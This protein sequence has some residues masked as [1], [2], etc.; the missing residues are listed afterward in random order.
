MLS[1]PSQESSDT[2]TEAQTSV[3]FVLCVR[4][5]RLVRFVLFCGCVFVCVPVC[6]FVRFSA[7]C[8]F[9]PAFRC[10]CVFTFAFSLSA[11]L[12]FVQSFCLPSL[13]AVCLFLLG[14]AVGEERKM[15]LRWGASGSR[16]SF[17]AAL[18]LHNFSGDSTRGSPVLHGRIRS[19]G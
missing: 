11:L 5:T 19:E 2:E 10:E 17:L 7:V 18:C 9:L 12:T 3:A 16:R 1:R 14:L 6:A 8:S 15:K 4:F 13:F